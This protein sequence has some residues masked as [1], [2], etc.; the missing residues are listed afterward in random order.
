MFS[1]RLKEKDNL[2]QTKLFETFSK[3]VPFLGTLQIYTLKRGTERKTVVSVLKIMLTD[4]ATEMGKIDE[5]KVKT[6]L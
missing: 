4:R 5:I 2:S 6:A 1:V 3:L